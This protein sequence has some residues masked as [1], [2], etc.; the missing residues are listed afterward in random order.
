[1][2][3]REIAN[4]WFGVG[5]IVFEPSMSDA[6]VWRVSVPLTQRPTKQ[7]WECPKCGAVMSPQTV[8]CLFCTPRKQELRIDQE[9]PDCV[10]QNESCEDVF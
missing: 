2:A 5:R 8:V 1:M 3:I 7:G 10:A 6:N 9:Q 4:G